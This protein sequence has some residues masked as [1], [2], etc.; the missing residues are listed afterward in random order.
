[1]DLQLAAMKQKCRRD[2]ESIRKILR[3]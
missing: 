3:D 2:W 1:M